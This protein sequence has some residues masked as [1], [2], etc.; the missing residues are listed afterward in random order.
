[1]GILNNTLKKHL[2]L[3]KATWKDKRSVS[4]RFISRCYK[5][6]NNYDEA[7]ERLDKAIKETPYLRVPL[8][9]RAFLAYD[10]KNMKT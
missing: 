2:T 8:V 3:K 5:K 4:K 9:E 10:K 7:K 1:M 6:L